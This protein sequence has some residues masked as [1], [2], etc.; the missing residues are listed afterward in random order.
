MAA[1]TICSD[2]GA[3]ENKVC[4]CFNCFPIYLPWSD[5]TGCLD[6]S[7]LNPGLQSQVG[8]R[9][10]HY[11]QSYWRWW[12]SSWAISNPE[13]WCCESAALN[14]RANVENSAVATKLEN[15]SSH[16]NPKKHTV[17]KNVQTITQLHSFHM[18]AKKCS[19]FHKIGF[20]SRWTESF[21]IFKL[22]IEKAKEPEIKL[23]A[24]IG[25]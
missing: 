13:R 25:S 2:F 15:V 21:W 3:Q 5:G 6:L 20:N 22:G 19:K 1:V 18:L 10:H 9:K 23:P 12:N 11:K 4:Y 7:F 16:S 8:L 24:S 17:P 14:M